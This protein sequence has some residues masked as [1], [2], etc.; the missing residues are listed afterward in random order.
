MRTVPDDESDINK[1][2]GIAESDKVGSNYQESIQYPSLN[3]NGIQSAWV[4][5]QSR[6][7]VPSTAEARLDVRTVL[8]NDPDKLIKIVKNH[9]QR[10]GFYIIDNEPTEEERMKHK[11]IISF[12]Y[13]YSYPAFRTEFNSVPGKWLSKII[14][15]AHKIEPIKIRQ[16]GGSI[17]IA[18][19]INALGVPAVILPT[20]NPDNNQHSPNENLRLVNYFNG[21]KTFLILFVT[22]INK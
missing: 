10:K 7:I 21:I 13:V 19:F 1:K 3:I 5:A 16:T 18:H 6:T 8:E 9:I 20:V 15:Y 17:P 2:L 4:G 11:K 14:N 22:P 12:N